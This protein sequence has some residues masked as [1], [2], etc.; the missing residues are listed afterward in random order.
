MIC[1]RCNTNLVVSNTQGVEV[2]HCP[3]CRGVWLDRG[4]LEKIIE[5]SNSYGSSW[6]GREHFD[7]HDDH[8]ED[9]HDKHHD[10]YRNGGFGFGHQPRRRKG[11]LSELFDF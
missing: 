8:H 10:S 3:N 1:P 4:E 2:D 7:H 5:R 6:E 11:F 9:H